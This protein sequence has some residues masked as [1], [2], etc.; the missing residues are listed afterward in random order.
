MVTQSLYIISILL[1][2]FV[3]VL[4]LR[5]ISFTRIKISWVLISIGFIMMAFRRFIEFSAHLNTK[6]YE[7]LS[8]ASEW[9]GIATSVVIAVGVWLIRDIFY[10]LKRAEIEQKRSE[11]KVLTAIMHTEEK[12]RRRFAEDIHDGLGPLLSTIKLYVNELTSE[13]LSIEEKK[14]SIN[15][16]NQLIDDAVSDIRTTANNLT[17]RVIHEY[18]LISAVEEFCNGISRTQKLNIQLDKP[19][20]KPEISK[21]AEINLYRII[22]ELINNTLKHSG[23]KSVTD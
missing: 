3:A 23:A 18:G 12:E 22:N 6:Y 7:E 9:I 17:P 10:S 16:I 8:R 5:F 14:D 21:H 4:A 15:Y 19:D 13:E 2:I 1:Q 11:R 20:L